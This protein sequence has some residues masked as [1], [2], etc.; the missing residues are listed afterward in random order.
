M[1]S[2]GEGYKKLSDAICEQIGTIVNKPLHDGPS[3]Y[4]EFVTWRNFEDPDAATGDHVK[5][6]AGLPF[7]KKQLARR[8]GSESGAGGD[9][10][11]FGISQRGEQ[12]RAL[13]DLCD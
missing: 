4:T 5:A 6:G 8:V 7:R 12:R 2:T 13:Q 9:E 3:P 1:T 10:G 11:Q